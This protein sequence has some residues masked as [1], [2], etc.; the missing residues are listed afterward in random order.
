[1]I[2]GFNSTNY[3]AIETEEV[4]T[5]CINVQNPPSGGALRPFTV[6]LIPAQGK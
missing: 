5:V 3:T 1:M 4:A 6:V 2:V